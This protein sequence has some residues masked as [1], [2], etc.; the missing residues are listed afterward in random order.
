MTEGTG[1][2]LI[3]A[4]MLGWALKAMAIF[5][6]CCSLCPSLHAAESGVPPKP[7][8]AVQRDAG[9]GKTVL[10]ATTQGQGA[11]CVPELQLP[12]VGWAATSTAAL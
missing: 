5:P 8:P 7:T 2:L 9:S 1:P 4:N 3:T 10:L 12:S 11:H 6:P